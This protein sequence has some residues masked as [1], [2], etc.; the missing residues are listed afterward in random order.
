[1]LHLRS[2]IDGFFL[3]VHRA[4]FTRVVASIKKQCLD[5]VLR[6]SHNLSRNRQP[7]RVGTLVTNQDLT[8]AAKRREAKGRKNSAKPVES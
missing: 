6:P 8:R 3:L 7:R 4:D 5:A 1:M 2:I